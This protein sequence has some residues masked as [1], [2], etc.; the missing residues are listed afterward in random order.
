MSRTRSAVPPR[1][2][3]EYLEPPAGLEGLALAAFHFAWDEEAIADRHPGALPQLSIFMCGEGEADFGERRDPVRPGAILISGLTCAAPYCMRGPWHA[4]GLSLSP[5][6]WAALTRQPASAFIDRFVPANELLGP[7]IDVVA[8]QVTHGYRDG[9][10]DG[11]GAC[12]MLADWVRPRLHP[13]PTA[14]GLLIRHTLDWIIS[15]LN[16]AL[17]RLYADSG[18]SRRQT[19]RLVERYFGLPPAALA[20]KY[21]AIRSA[22]L[23]AQPDLSDREQAEI[24][25][26]FYDQPHMVR[27]IRRYCG[28]TPTRLGGEAEPLF[29]TMLAMRNFGRLA[30]VRSVPPGPDAR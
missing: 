10:I 27:E 20:R 6:G 23:L 8:Q 16:P 18:Y 26:A 9:T 29:Q 28:Y 3:L 22:A 15:G 30:R 17:E 25:E 4:V 14:H 13:V 5:L 11:K 12:A 19:E 2:Q 1:F 21:R 7:D 24:A